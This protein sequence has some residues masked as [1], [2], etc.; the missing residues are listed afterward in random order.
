MGEY[1]RGKLLLPQSSRPVAAAAVNV[2]AWPWYN[3]ALPVDARVEALLRAMTTR[4]KVLQ[5]QTEPVQAVPRLGVPCEPSGRLHGRRVCVWPE[6]HP[7]RGR[8]V[9]FCG[10]SCTNGLQCNVG[11]SG[12][13]ALL[14]FPTRSLP[15][16]S[17]ARSFWLVGRVPSRECRAPAADP[18][19][20]CGHC[21]CLPVPTRG[22]FPPTR[23][24]ARLHLLP[25][26]SPVRAWGAALPAATCMNAPLY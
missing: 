16:S 26:C 5:L 25:A 4:E 8:L 1:P 3:H 14:L 13:H 22:H 9:A 7:P 11:V 12:T 24:L 23:L 21:P 10:R 19:P 2:A 15:I 17:R 6:V 18:L 20:A